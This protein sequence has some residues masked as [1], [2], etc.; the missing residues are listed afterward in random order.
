[1]IGKCTKKLKKGQHV[2]VQIVHEV[3]NA[4]DVTLV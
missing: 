1:M 4:L 3:G 2:S